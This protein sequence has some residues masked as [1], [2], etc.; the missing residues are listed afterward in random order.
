VAAEVAE[1]CQ[2]ACHERGH[3]GGALNG[4]TLITAEALAQMKWRL[5]DR[6]RVDTAHFVRD[7]IVATLVVSFSALFIWY[8]R[9]TGN[10]FW[11]Y[12]SPFF[13]TIVA[14]ALGVPVYRAQR[15]RDKRL[16]G[17]PSAIA[18]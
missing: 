11:V 14:F 7:T 10:G 8:S 13:L 5:I 3:R 12:W 6:R 9:Y 15:R 16:A 1:A 17:G 2:R 4:W 18:P